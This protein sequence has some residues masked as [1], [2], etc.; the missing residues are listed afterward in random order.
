MT[1]RIQWRSPADGAYC[2][3]LRDVQQGIRGG[4]D[5]IY[6]LSLQPASPGFSLNLAA[7]FANV[8]QGAKGEIELTSRRTGGFTGPIDLQVEGLPEGVRYEPRQL[9]AGQ[10]TIKL[11]F[12]A[13]DQARPRDVPLKILGSATHEGTPLSAVALAPHLGQDSDGVSAGPPQVDHIQLTVRHKPM[14]R[15]YC[16]EAYQYAYRGTVYPYAMEVE[17]LQGF[18]GPIHVEVADR[19]IKDLDGIVVRETT[20]EP[21]QSK[22]MLPVY[23]PE[24][25]HIN[26]QAHSNV[27]AQAYVVFQDA[28]GQQQSQ[29][30]VSEMR[31]MIRPLPA[32]AK[33]SVVDSEISAR[34]GE[35]VACNLRLDRTSLF[36]GAMHVELVEPRADSG[37]LAQPIT[38]EPDQATAII[39]VRLPDKPSLPIPTQLKFRA[40]GELP[41]YARVVSE[42]TV[43]LDLPLSTTFSAR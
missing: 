41:G 29:A 6:R 2:L 34:L 27:Y 1:C 39:R 19:Q 4:P 23:L 9:A 7:D 3:R 18:T 40:T 25:M 24:T 43:R 20:L 10:D 12:I 35:S 32:V 33:L 26:V 8:V 36:S 14:L 16:S 11:A 21:G 15:I 22:F 28:W 30:F 38:I 13:D 5:F 37:C 17:R 31:C 42:A